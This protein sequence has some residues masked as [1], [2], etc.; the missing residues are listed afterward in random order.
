M[1]SHGANQHEFLNGSGSNTRICISAPSTGM[2]S[3]MTNLEAELM[4]PP[5]DLWVGYLGTWKN[6]RG[7]PK[8]PCYLGCLVASS[9]VFEAVY[10]VPCSSFWC[11]W[12]AM[13]HHTKL[14]P[15]CLVQCIVPHYFGDRAVSSNR[16]AKK[17]HCY[18]WQQ[19]T[20]VHS[21]LFICVFFSF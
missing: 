8:C 5:A 12:A 13:W 9:P 14:L 2:L 1:Q 17:W 19:S 21:A 6:W 4:C 20:S 16:D 15:A 10:L 3:L 18:K 11:P 7:A